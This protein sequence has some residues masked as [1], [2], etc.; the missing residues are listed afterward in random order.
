LPPGPQ[1]LPIIGNALHLMDKRWLISRDCKERFG[2][3]LIIYPGDAKFVEITGEI[4]YLDAA[5][6]PTIMSTLYDYPTLMSED[7]EA[8]ERIEEYNRRWRCLG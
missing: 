2:E 5:G 7:D 6:Q 4:M 1:H 3:L 8:I